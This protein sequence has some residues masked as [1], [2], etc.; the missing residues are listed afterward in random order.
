MVTY[1]QIQNEVNKPNRS[2]ILA[3][4]ERLAVKHTNFVEMEFS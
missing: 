4:T 2:K 3:W 1:L